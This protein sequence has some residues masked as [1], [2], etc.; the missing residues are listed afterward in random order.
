MR[1]ASTGERVLVL[2]DG[3]RIPVSR[4]R[5]EQVA[6]LIRRTTR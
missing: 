2:R 5:R 1:S 4:R 3:T 6:E